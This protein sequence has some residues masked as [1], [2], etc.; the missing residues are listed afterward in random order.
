MLAYNARGCEFEPRQE[1]WV[2]L[3]KFQLLEIP[4]DKELTANCL[5]DTRT[6]LEEL[7]PA[8]MVKYGLTRVQPLDAAVPD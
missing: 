1:N 6:K 3:C 8:A 2:L 5:A 4:L 7:I